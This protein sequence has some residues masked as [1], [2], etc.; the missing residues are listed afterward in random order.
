ME[1]GE[2]LHIVVEATI[3]VEAK[4]KILECAM[5]GHEG[6][7]NLHEKST[8]MNQ[9]KK[10]RQF[11]NDAVLVK[12]VKGRTYADLLSGLKKGLSS[13]VNLKEEI[14][15]VRQTREGHMLVEVKKGSKEI[16][17]LCQKIRST[18]YMES[19]TKIGREVSKVVN[20][21][22]IDLD[23]SE[24]EVEEAIACA[25]KAHGTKGDVNIKAL[26][27]MSGGRKAATAVGRQEVIQELINIGR[28]KIGFSLVD[29][30]KR[31][32][33]T[34]CNR[35][36][37]SG[38]YARDC[39]GVDRTLL[40]RNCSKEGHKIQECK[41]DPYCMECRVKGHRT[42]SGGCRRMNEKR[43]G[44]QGE[45]VR[46]RMADQAVITIPGSLE[47]EDSQKTKGG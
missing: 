34:R 22:G 38:H 37:G 3:P 17:K 1:K 19:A 8:V 11:I 9:G 36:W 10:E 33:E 21:Y 40:C 7:I 30:K 45:E 32:E 41:S 44:T 18:P 12:G 13:E 20:L 26:R 42:A 4:R 14:K 28:I 35:C 25:L 46:E 31:D 29:I 43:I 5:D 39:R 15:M 6:N 27:P 16:E 2:N 23:V 47:R 24:R